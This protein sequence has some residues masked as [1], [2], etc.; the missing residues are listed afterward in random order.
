MNSVMTRMYSSARSA[1]AMPIM[2]LR[3][4]IEPSLPEWLYPAPLVNAPA[5]HTH[6]GTH[7]P[8]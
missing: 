3:K 7:A 6:G 1:F 8:F 2:P 4:L 5:L